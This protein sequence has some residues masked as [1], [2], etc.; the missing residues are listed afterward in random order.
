[1]VGVCEDVSKAERRCSGLLLAVL[2]YEAL[3]CHRRSPL[4]VRMV[5]RH[6]GSGY[7]NE[8]GSELMTWPFP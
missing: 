7:L 4:R 1:M 3:R 5:F 2:T 6:R 8:E